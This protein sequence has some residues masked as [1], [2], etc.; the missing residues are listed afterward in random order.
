MHAAGGARAEAPATE[1]CDDAGRHRAT[2]MVCAAADLRRYHHN[3]SAIS[4]PPGRMSSTAKYGAIS[5]TC[6]ANHCNHVFI[7]SSAF[8]LAS[9]HFSVLL[10]RSEFVRSF[11]TFL[12]LAVDA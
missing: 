2:P 9:L 6:P 10:S 12:A 3:A 7:D 8:F 1:P 11:L 4:V 5:R